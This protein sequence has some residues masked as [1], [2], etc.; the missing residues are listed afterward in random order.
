MHYLGTHFWLHL[1]LLIYDYDTSWGEQMYAYL[2]NPKICQYLHGYKLSRCT[3]YLQHGVIPS[4]CYSSLMVV[5]SWKRSSNVARCSE[6]C[7]QHSSMILYTSSGHKFGFA[8]SVR[9]LP[10]SASSMTCLSD[11]S[12]C[13]C[14]FARVKISHMVI[15]NA[16]TSD[17]CENLP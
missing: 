6:L 17:F 4:E 1:M 9:F 16:H 10:L 15:P 11:M 7:A 5:S 13:G 14:S 8:N 12:L 2:N 3:L